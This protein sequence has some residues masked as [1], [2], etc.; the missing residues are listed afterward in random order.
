[1]QDQ[2]VRLGKGGAL[3]YSR[4]LVFSR[5]PNDEYDSFERSFGDLRV[6]KR[7][8]ASGKRL[9]TLTFYWLGELG[10]FSKWQDQAVKQ[11]GFTALTSKW[12]TPWAACTV[13]LY[14]C[15]Q[16]AA[17]SWNA[18]SNTIVYKNSERPR[19]RSMKENVWFACPIW[20]DEQCWVKLFPKQSMQGTICF[21]EGFVPLSFS[22][23]IYSLGNAQVK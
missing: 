5:T 19:M 12:Q 13:Y 3:C 10:S 4:G 7:N 1:M 6:W 11:M 21:H 17:A 23:C 8:Y 14:E 9:N 16:D 20:L 18:S 2:G 15:R 22:L